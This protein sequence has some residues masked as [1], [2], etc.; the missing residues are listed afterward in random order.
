MLYLFSS[1]VVLRLCKYFGL[2]FVVRVGFV[3]VVLYQACL[4]SMFR[5]VICTYIICALR[6]IELF[7]MSLCNYIPLPLA[8]R[9]CEFW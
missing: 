7:I 8:S 2:K 3:G 1:I 4:P 9:L 5:I 6:E